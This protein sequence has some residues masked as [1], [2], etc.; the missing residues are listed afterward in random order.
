MIATFMSLLFCCHVVIVV[1]ACGVGMSTMG[2]VV[3]RDPNSFCG[4]DFCV[5]VRRVLRREVR[6]TGN[7]R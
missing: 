3:G 2:V 1:V 7:F 4:R 6:E 5:R